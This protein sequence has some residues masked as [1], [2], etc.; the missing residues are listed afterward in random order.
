MCFCILFT[1]GVKG[2]TVKILGSMNSMFSKFTIKT[3]QRLISVMPFGIFI[4]KTE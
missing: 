4:V 2:L 1:L 3:I